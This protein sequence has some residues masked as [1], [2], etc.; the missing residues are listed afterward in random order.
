VDLIHGVRNASSRALA[1]VVGAATPPWRDTTTERSTVAREHTIDPTRI[2]HEWDASLQPTLRIDSEDIVN[3]DIKMA[4]AGQVENG[5]SFD[6]TSFDFDTLYNLLGPIHVE[7][8]RPGDTLEV[9][10][11]ELRTGDWGWTSVLP[12][13]GTLP[14]EFPDPFIRYFD[15]TKGD[16]TTLV[17][18][19]EIP[20]EPFLGT[21]G[22]LPDDIEKATPFPP[23]KGGGN[24]DTRHLRMGT[25]FF[26]PVFREGALFSCGDGHAAQG[27]G[28]V[29]VAAIETDM[30]A[31]LRFR[32]H[33][34]K[35]IKAPR[36]V[37]PGPLTPRVDAGGWYGTMGIDPDLMEGARKAISAMVELIAT[38][39]GLDRE[40]AYVLCSLA[41]DLKILEIVDAGVWNVG[42]TLPRSVFVN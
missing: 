19:V 26:L 6:R 8:A 32:L 20:I 28:E 12:E 3:F 30:K 18:G 40:D 33:S 38:E 22:V 17:P 39:H 29:C 23:H 34:G 1:A 13:L 7:G 11:V 31:T 35:T 10:I 9:E 25:S 27:D 24:V 2:H 37:V 41:G 4:G 14:D 36:F 42:F 15:L 16:T 5:W 21:M